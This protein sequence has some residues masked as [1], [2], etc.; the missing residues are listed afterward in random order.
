MQTFAMQ[1]RIWGEDGK[2]QVQHGDSTSE[3]HRGIF[4]GMDRVAFGFRRQFPRLEEGSGRVGALIRGL[5]TE[6]DGD[7]V[8]GVISKMVHHLSP[9]NDTELHAVLY[10]L[11]CRIMSATRAS[12]FLRDEILVV[13]DGGCDCAGGDADGEPFGSSLQALEE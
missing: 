2:R 9:Y 7:S 12:K 4:V 5:K 10:H 1:G 11:S 3:S 8:Q 13:G 6:S